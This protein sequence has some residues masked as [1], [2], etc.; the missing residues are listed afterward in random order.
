MATKEAAAPRRRPKRSVGGSE[1]D[2]RLTDHDIRSE[3]VLLAGR[4]W[5]KAYRMHVGSVAFRAFI[6][7]RVPHYLAAKHNRSDT[8]RVVALAANSIGESTRSR[9]LKMIV[10]NK[11]GEAEG[12]R[13]IRRGT[14]YYWKE[15]DRRDWCT[16]LGETLRDRIKSTERSRTGTLPLPASS[17]TSKTI[18]FTDILKG[19]MQEFERG[20]AADQHGHQLDARAREEVDEQEWEEP[21]QLGGDQD[22]AALEGC[23]CGKNEE[24]G[25]DQAGASSGA[26]EG[27]RSSQEVEDSSSSVVGDASTTDQQMEDDSKDCG[28]AIE[29]SSLVHVADISPNDILLGATPRARNHLG[30][31]AFRAF[32]RSK[33]IAYIEAKEKDFGISVVVA[34]ATESLFQTNP[35]MLRKAQD[36]E[37]YWVPVDK[38]SWF[39][40]MGHAIR[41]HVGQFKKNAPVKRKR[42]HKFVTDIPSFAKALADEIAACK[43]AKLVLDAPKQSGSPPSFEDEKEQDTGEDIN[44]DAKKPAATDATEGVG[45]AM[46]HEE[47]DPSILE[48]ETHNDTLMQP[49]AS[50]CS[51]S[52]VRP[53]V[54]IL[55]AENASPARQAGQ[56]TTSWPERESLEHFEVTPSD[57]LREHN[58]LMRQ[59][60]LASETGNTQ[61]LRSLQSLLPPSVLETGTLPL[62][63]SLLRNTQQPER[64][65][66]TRNYHRLPT[67]STRADED[68]ARVSSLL[69]I[70]HDALLRSQELKEQAQRQNDIAAA[71]YCQI[72]ML[73]NE[74]E[75]IATLNAVELFSRAVRSRALGASADAPVFALRR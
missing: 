68:Q 37:D 54:E 74:A 2:V 28:S 49:A 41:Y 16:L 57:I 40:N 6:A 63:P 67:T 39:L 75:R 9:I 35:R 50:V 27:E 4:C 42:Y 12:A 33:T 31:K 21:S 65:A 48:D 17:R 46:Q 14:W 69:K 61:L 36:V 55:I 53:E 29:D 24:V 52:N 59:V 23:G 70:H 43:H 72:A 25:K 1:D 26:A 30:S 5:A 73:P 38:K 22:L 62:A 71:A 47:E 13:Q 64:I 56:T 3:D 7:S 51:S 20:V 45:G 58:E 32:A 60:R 8:I 66:A 44:D 15:I 18:S 11:P 19:T 34:L 10:V